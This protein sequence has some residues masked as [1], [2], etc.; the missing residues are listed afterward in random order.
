MSSE[1]HHHKKISQVPVNKGSARTVVGQGMLPT[2]CRV[3]VAILYCWYY[4][5]RSMRRMIALREA[6]QCVC[7]DVSHWHTC[8]HIRKYVSSIV[9]KYSQWGVSSTI[10]E[11][12]Y[13]QHTTLWLTTCWYSE[14]RKT[15]SLTVFYISALL[16]PVIICSIRLWFVCLF[17][18]LFIS[19][20]RNAQQINIFLHSGL[21]ADACRLTHYH[22]VPSFMNIITANISQVVWW[23]ISFLF[24]IDCHQLFLISFQ[25][26]KKV[27]KS[28]W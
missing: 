5:A 28:W 9:T 8:W 11:G 14:N 24:F 21:P 13:L 7:A 20:Y 26:S 12:C 18:E 19:T 2:E 17:N 6:D 22:S 3:H 15:S 25:S 1:D 16:V 4:F 23:T 10:H 27:S